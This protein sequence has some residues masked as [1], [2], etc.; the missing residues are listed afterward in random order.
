MPKYT[1][2][3]VQ[4]FPIESD[5]VLLPISSGWSM[6]FLSNQTLPMFDFMKNS[7][8]SGKFSYKLKPKSS[9]STYTNQGYTNLKVRGVIELPPGDPS[10]LSVGSDWFPVANYTNLNQSQFK[11]IDF[12]IS[13]PLTI[14]Q[15]LHTAKVKFHIEGVKNSITEILSTYEIPVVLN[16]F[17]EGYYYTPNDFTFYY[18][19]GSAL[20]QVLKVGGNNWRV[21]VPV[22]LT[23]TGSNVVQNPDG[24]FYAADSGLKNFNIG[25]GANFDQLLGD[26]SSIVLP[27]TVVYTTGSYTIPVTIIQAGNYYPT[28]TV[29]NIQNGQVDKLFQMINLTRADNYTVTAPAN[30]GYELL[31]TSSGKKIKIFILDPDGFGSGFFALSLSIIYP[32]ATYIVYITVNVGNQ[33]DLGLDFS[34]V[35]TH[36]M[37]DLVFSTNNEDSYINMVLSVVGNGNSFTYQFPFFK[38]R[39]T[40]NIGKALSNFIDYENSA[41]FSVAAPILGTY[42]WERSYPLSYFNLN[43][44]ERKAGTD[45]LNFNKSN[46]SFVLGYKPIVKNNVAILQHNNFSRFTAKSFALISVYS[47]TGVFDYKITKNNVE[48]ASVVQAF[49]YIRIL[50]LDFSLYNGTAGDIFDFILQPGIDEIKKSFVIF[51]EALESINVVYLDSFGLYSCLNFTGNTKNVASQFSFKMENYLNKTYLNTRKHLEKESSTIVL[52]TGFLL[53]SQ[54]LE[55][56]ELMKAQKAWVIINDQEIIELIPKTEKIDEESNDDFLYSYAIEF[57]INKEKYAQGYNF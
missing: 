15:G 45:L 35:F 41:T 47:L 10:W 57:E 25:L 24:S 23:L 56:S 5:L 44:I 40:K 16:V 18:T 8:Q 13:A 43:V 42:N 38:G 39:A 53:K 9:Y 31:N 27:V 6:M 19:S 22:G 54:N 34:T 7:P 3:P 32:D 48:V 2:S 33:F 21:N 1:L 17:E 30:I 46:V 49:G 36:S 29:F 11:D 14:S 20:S 26:N 55:V 28:Q 52:N 50:K 12:M 37:H 51:P 4:K